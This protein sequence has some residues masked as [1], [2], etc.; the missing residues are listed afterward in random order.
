MIDA[1]LHAWYPFSIQIGFTPLHYASWNGHTDIVKLLIDHGAHIDVPTKV[2][3]NI[4]LA[5][6]MTYIVTH[7]GGGQ[8][9]Y[10]SVVSMYKRTQN[11]Y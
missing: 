6:C 9:Y 11:C 1:L 5:T 2:G 7:S 4:Y 8:F 10:C 3:V